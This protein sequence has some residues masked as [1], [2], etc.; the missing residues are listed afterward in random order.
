MIRKTLLTL[1][2]LSGAITAKAT[3]FEQFIIAP[4]TF[5]FNGYRGAIYFGDKL[6]VNPDLPCKYKRLAPT[7]LQF[8]DQEGGVV[9]RIDKPQAIPPLQAN[10]VKAGIQAFQSGTDTASMALKSL[11]IDVDL[12]PVADTN[13]FPANP[14]NRAYSLSPDIA[15]QYASAFS[16]SLHRASI[17]PTWKHFPG[18]SQHVYKLPETSLAYKQWYKANYVES[19]IDVSTID[20]I[21]NAMTAFRDNGKNLMMVNS[22]YFN[23]L[24]MPA[25]FSPDI[26]KYAHAMQPNSLLITDD[27][28]ELKLT[29]ERVLFLFNNYDLFL[30]SS[31]QSAQEFEQKLSDLVLEGKIDDK[32]IGDKSARV[33]KFFGKAF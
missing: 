3:E 14:Q 30:F 33:N 16:A 13:F 7:Q 12:A 4:Q 15:R 11:C 31:T 23:S 17:T 1:L 26:V 28:A 9:A 24:N 22:A 21:K 25:V 18:Y 29:D 19:S 2:L 32:A 10:A 20:Q 6:K 5:G 27:V 8:I